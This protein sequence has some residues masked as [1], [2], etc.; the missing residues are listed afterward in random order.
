[1]YE[2]KYLGT[3]TLSI[4]CIVAAVEIVEVVEVVV[5]ET[6]LFS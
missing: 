5:E 4:I 3:K 1:M 6:I 2:L